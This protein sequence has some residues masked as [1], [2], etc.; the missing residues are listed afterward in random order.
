[1]PSFFTL[2]YIN[3][4]DAKTPTLA[5]IA[6]AQAANPLFAYDRGHEQRTLVRLQRIYAA[7]LAQMEAFLSFFDEGQPDIVLRSA[8]QELALRLPACPQISEIYSGLRDALA[9]ELRNLEKEIVAAHLDIERDQRKTE[10]YKYSEPAHLAIIRALCAPAGA[11][12]AALVTSLAAES[13]VSN[14]A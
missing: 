14:A 2:Q 3:L 8:S 13:P 5:D 12:M 1:M 6:A 9:D 11:T 4:M 10:K 7:K